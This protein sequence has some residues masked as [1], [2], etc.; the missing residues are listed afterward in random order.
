VTC[1]EGQL[2]TVM[3]GNMMTVRGYEVVLEDTIFFPE[4]GGQVYSIHI[5]FI[6]HSVPFLLSWFKSGNT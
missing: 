6:H 3:G 4:G 1:T 5:I 2:K